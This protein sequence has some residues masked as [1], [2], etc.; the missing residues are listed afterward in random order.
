MKKHLKVTII[1]F[2]S[3]GVFFSLGLFAL[4]I[5]FKNNSKKELI[6]SAQGTEYIP[7]D[8]RPIKMVLNDDRQLKII[9]DFE[10][11]SVDNGITPDEYS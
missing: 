5:I 3:M 1:I 4:K 2:F 10:T 8:D 7:R 11:C 9:N 6:M